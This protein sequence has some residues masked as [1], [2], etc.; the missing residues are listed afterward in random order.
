MAFGDSL[1]LQSFFMKKLRLLTAFA[2][3][4]I[5]IGF[6]NISKANFPDQAFRTDSLPGVKKIKDIMIYE[7]AQFY[8]SFPSIVKRPNGE[9][10]LAFRRAPGVNLFKFLL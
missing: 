3:C 2:V 9:L 8:S 5:G 10:L 7:D 6:V 4:I 1:L